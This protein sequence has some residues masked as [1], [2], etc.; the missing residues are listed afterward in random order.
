MFKGGDD[1]DVTLEFPAT[2]LPQGTE[3]WITMAS[4]ERGALRCGDGGS[5]IAIHG[6]SMAQAERSYLT[7]QHCLLKDSFQALSELLARANDL[8]AAVTA[9]LDLQNVAQKEVLLDARG[10]AGLVGLMAMA[11]SPIQWTATASPFPPRRQDK[12]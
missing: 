6:P 4:R 2:I 7:W 1:Y 9:L 11:A 8:L 3:L 10:P 12:G 5:T